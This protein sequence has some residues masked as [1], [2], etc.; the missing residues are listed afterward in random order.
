[1]NKSLLLPLVGLAVIMA[2]CTMTPKYNRPTAPVPVAWP[3]GPAY[4]APLATTNLQLLD[5]REFFTDAKLRQV[6]G[7]ALTNNRDLRLAALN[8]ERSRALYGIQR[9]ELLPVVNATG[10]GIKQRVPADL[11][12]TG[13][14][15]TVERYDANLGVAA[16]E[17]DFFGRI[18]SLTDRALAEYLAT[19][20]ARRSTQILL[21]SSAA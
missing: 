20:Q 10:S 11:S 1:M 18:R 9:A 19:E 4:S 6:I 8:V 16:W 15:Q 3:T 12:S 17:I 7:M 14:R 13:S 5:W 21:V 2:G